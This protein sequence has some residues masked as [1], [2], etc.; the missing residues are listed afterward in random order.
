M[1]CF[2]SSLHFPW[3]LKER[4][5]SCLRNS[6]HFFSRK[7]CLKNTKQVTAMSYLLTHGWEAALPQIELFDAEDHVRPCDVQHSTSSSNKWGI[8]SCSQIILADQTSLGLGATWQLLQWEGC[9]SWRG[10][11]CQTWKRKDSASSRT[12][13]FRNDGAGETEGEFSKVSFWP[14][15]LEECEGKNLLST[16]QVWHPGSREF[17]STAR[18]CSCNPA[19]QCGWHGKKCQ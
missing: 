4:K 12:M 18:R 5:H 6:I 15:S 11:C 1:R 10:S 7:H 14:L 13:Q 3:F 9:C 8:S 2:F 16:H 17:V 19:E